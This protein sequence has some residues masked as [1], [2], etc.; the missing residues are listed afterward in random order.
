MPDQVAG[1]IRAEI[2]KGR[3]STTVPG[4]DKLAKEFGV[5]GKTVEAALRA[6]QKQGLLESQ[7]SG[8]RR[9][10]VEK[11]NTATPSLRIAILTF[12]PLL[13]TD[14]Y[15]IKL[16]HQL[17][18]AGY[19]AFFTKK[20]LTELDFDVKKVSRFVAQTKADAWIVGSAPRNVLEW[21]AEQPIP[22]FALFGRRHGLPI[23]GVGPDKNASISEATRRLLDLGHQ[24]I[25]L[26]ARKSRRLPTPGA[27]ERVFLKELA[28][29]GILTSNYHLPDWV[30][31][32][33]GFR[34]G[35]EALFRITPPTALIVDE[36]QF[37]LA[38]LQFCANRGLKVPGDISLISTDN[39][40]HFEWFTP[41]VAHI[42]W[43]RQPVISRIER[44]AAN[45]SR[46]KKDL[47]Q[48]LTKA[49]FIEGGTIGPVPA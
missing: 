40:G 10:I 43:H 35:L 26:I 44:W 28:D 38:A 21:L 46:G 7:G 30:E 27:G 22:T 1:S 41:S 48:T 49:E 45:I 14:G 13:L 5:S 18:A 23:A 4:R 34:E 33:S 11:M 6:L 2:T 31:T 12:D 17:S 15:M 8:R 37:F 19:S 24:R 32:V 36:A 42:H 25:A 9:R 16:Q 3:W 47:R 20:S 29:H 39:D